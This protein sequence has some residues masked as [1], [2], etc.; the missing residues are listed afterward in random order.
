MYKISALILL[1]AVGIF[2]LFE[3]KARDLVQNLVDNELEI[4]AMNAIDMATAQVLS[5]ENIDYS[6]FVKSICNSEGMVTSLQTDSSQINI[7]KSRI[8]LAITEKIRQ[9]HKVTVGVP[10]GAFTGFVLLSDKGPDI[11]VSLTLGGSAITDITSEFISAGINQTIHRIYM[12]VD[13]DISLTCPIIAYE[14]NVVT[15]YQLCE[16]VIVGSTPQFFAGMD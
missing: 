1:I 12:T 10:A 11:Y 16:T 4:H 8:S 14:T 5:E 2:C 6:T 15:Q 7:L 3:F 9:D 13:A